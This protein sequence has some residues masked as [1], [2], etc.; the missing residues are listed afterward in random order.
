[1]KQRTVSEVVASLPPEVQATAQE[2][3]WLRQRTLMPGLIE[4]LD[5][6]ERMRFAELQTELQ[7][8]THD[9]LA[10]VGRSGTF[11]RNRSKAAREDS[12][13]IVSIR[14]SS[15]RDWF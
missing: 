15:V 3:A 6:E 7:P 2:L 8:H 11:W 12:A 5:E 4:N 9:I 10:A 13:K 14:I 1:M